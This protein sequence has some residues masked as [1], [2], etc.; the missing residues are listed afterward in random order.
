MRRIKESKAFTLIELIMVI[1]IIGI[2][3]ATAI[4]RYIGLQDDAKLA[5]TQGTA[6]AVR[7]GISVWHANALIKDE[8]TVWPL[9]LDSATDGDAGTGVQAFFISVLEDPGITDD[10]S[11]AGLVYTAPNGGTFTYT[12]ADG[13][14]D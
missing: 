3:A 2:L 12:T 9:A 10:W 14:F 11:K 13:A 6:G 5:A 8:T 7:G 1:V 4:P